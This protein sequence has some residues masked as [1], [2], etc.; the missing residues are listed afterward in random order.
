MKKI[1]DKK[2]YDTDT[3]KFIAEYHN[4]LSQSDHGYISEE[5]YVT[6]NG[7]YFLYGSG[8]PLSIYSESNGN[9]SWGTSAIVLMDRNEV[10]DWLEKY[11]FA[12]IIEEIF[13]GEI[14]KG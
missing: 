6:K 9:N 10:Y 4:G 13:E 14:Q 11:N 5:L 12:D 7:Q 8:G 1:I 3:S 2:V